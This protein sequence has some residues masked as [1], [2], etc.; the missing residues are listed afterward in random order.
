MAA[1]ITSPS[2]ERIK[3]LIRLRERVHR[4]AE[5][6]FLVEG[7]REYRRAITA[8][9]KP[10]VTFVSDI[11]VDTEGDTFT[12]APVALDR[13]SY[14]QRSQGVIGV[15]SQLDTSLASL[16][17]AGLSLVLVV[18]AIE[19]PG[20]LGA[21]LR[22]A[23]AAGA[24]AVVAVGPRPDVHNPNT[25]RASTGAL[26]TMP[27]VISEWGE[28]NPW[29]TDQGLAIV[30]ASPDAG[31][32]MWEVDLSGPLALVVGAEDRG[33]SP[34]AT[35]AADRMVAIPQQAP[36]V[37]SLNVSVAAALLLYESRRQRSGST[38]LKSKGVE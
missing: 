5:G 17:P 10:V 4:D 6:V 28:L 20:N 19:K 32:S 7:E 21:I 37:D 13:A 14:R 16:K 29:L 1:D 25:V 35:E 8:G 26:F 36:T 24:D 23:A 30:A 15:F 9:L 22:T 33:L 11:S 27:V 31:V 34:A 38:N 18:E 12:V 2:N 3:W